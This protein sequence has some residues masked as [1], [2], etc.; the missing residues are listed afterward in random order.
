ME[1]TLRGKKQQAVRVILHHAAMELFTKNGF[2][3]TT[4]EEIAEAAGVSK[5]SFFRYF[6]TKADLLAE[7]VVNYGAALAESI[8]TSS[9]ELS[10]FEVMEETV[11]SGVRHA[12]RQEVRTRQVVEIA[13]GS[14]SARQA[15]QFRL[16]EVEDT[17][18]DA[19]AARFKSTSKA[20]VNPRL[21][22]G[23]TLAIMSAIISSW[24]N[25]E[26]KDLST[27]A[28]QVLR[29]LSQT[30]CGGTCDARQSRSVERRAR[31]L[32]ERGQSLAER[33]AAKSISAPH[34]NR[35]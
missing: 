12:A 17:L 10:A 16:I 24:F 27:S 26:Y 14:L 2:D 22:A 34:K 7:S 35:R 21:L 6:E 5:R 15:Y 29:S 13:I 20:K 18:T 32:E 28:R 31:A 33:S 19:F 9:P 23:V 8:R 11:R 4:V 25:G 30:V 1:G 3:S